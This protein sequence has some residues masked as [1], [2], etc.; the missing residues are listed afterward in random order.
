MNKILYEGGDGKSL[1][2]AIIIM[3]VV[4]EQL[5][6]MAEYEYISKIYGQ[7]PTYWKPIKQSSMNKNGKRFDVITIITIPENKEVSYYFDISN[8]YGKFF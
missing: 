4:N 5:G 3:G 8:F 2:T 7:A 1:K 6:V